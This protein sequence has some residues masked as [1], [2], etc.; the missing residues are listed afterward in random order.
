MLTDLLDLTVDQICALRRYR[1]T[2]ETVIRWLKK[3]LGLDHLISYSP[4]G[5][6]LQ[7]TMALIVYGLLV[8]YTQGQPLSVA[9]LRRKIRTDLHQ[10][11]YEWGWKQGY[12]AAFAEHSGPGP[13]VQIPQLTEGYP[14]VVEAEK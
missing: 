2:V 3:Q 14:R 7:V 11:L 10:A 5:V 13:P 1:W 9:R 12:Q 8:L 4:R 6:I